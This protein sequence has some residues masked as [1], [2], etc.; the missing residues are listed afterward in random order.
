LTFPSDAIIRG[1]CIKAAHCPWFG[2]VDNDSIDC[3][4]RTRDL[5]KP[6]FESGWLR[7]THLAI[8]LHIAVQVPQEACLIGPKQIICFASHFHA[9]YPV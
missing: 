6:A 8:T 5:V 7:I 9:V 2:P 4:Y 1:R 3:N